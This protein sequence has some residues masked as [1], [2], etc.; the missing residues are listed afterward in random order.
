MERL[1][2][3]LGNSSLADYPEGGGHWSVFLQYLLGLA[4][5]GHDVFLL[6]LLWSAGEGRDEEWI[7]AFFDRLQQYG[8]QDRAAIL[9]WDKSIEDPVLELAEPFGR[10]REQI[11]ALARDVDLLWNF[12]AAFRQ[13]L[14]SRFRR[15]ALIDLDPGHLQ[16]ADLTCDMG[17][18]DHHVFLTCGRNVGSPGGQVPTLDLRWQ[19]F[20]PFVYLPMWSVAADPGLEAPF[21]SVTQWTWDELRL[22]ERVLSLS[23]RDAYLR[24]LDLPHRAGRPFELAANIHPADDTDDRELLQANGWRLVHPHVVAASPAAYQAYLARSRAEICCP[25]PIFRELRTGWFSDRS[26]GYLASGRPVLA[27][28]TGFSDFLPTGAGL[29]AFR[30]M[31]EA[32][33]GVAEIDRN[34]ARHQAAARAL[35]ENCLDSRKT[36]PLMLAACE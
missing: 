4:D 33:A 6:E 30:D 19:P 1:R 12:C 10:T 28:D 29:I 21:T 24:F 27:E 25:K 13:P 3:V 9:L 5:L 18:R 32:I 36:L 14:L 8:L 26:A 35:A 31:A 23:K 7:G 20:T 22:Q 15:R 2:I 34:Y 11:A 16:V 17:V